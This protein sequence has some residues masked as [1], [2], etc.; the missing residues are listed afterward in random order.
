MGTG[1]T[2]AMLN[3][4]DPRTKYLVVHD[5]LDQCDSVLA[6]PSGVEFHQPSNTSGSKAN[7]LVRLVRLGKN[8]ATTHALYPSLVEVARDGYLRDY[9]IIIDE[10]LDPVK[11]M[12]AP[13]E[14]VWDALVAAGYVYVDQNT[15]KVIPTA[16]WA[17]NLQRVDGTLTQGLLEAATAGLLYITEKREMFVLPIPVELVNS[18]NSVTIAT[19]R[20]RGS[21]LAAYLDKMGIPYVI[22]RDISLDRKLRADVRRWVTV[23]DIPSLREVR[24]SKSGQD[25]MA[26]SDCRKVQVALKNVRQ[27]QLR[28]TPTDQILVGCA[29]DSWYHTNGRKTYEDRTG[30]FSKG[31]GLFTEANWAPARVRGTNEFREC[32]VVFSLYDYHISPP[33]LEWLGKEDDK[34]FKDEYA[35]SELLQF[36]FRSRIRCRETLADPSIT[37]YIPSERMRSLFLDWANDG[38]PPEAALRV[39]R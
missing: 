9:V 28:N 26:S 20:A 25:K 5:T 16:R 2:T 29:K 6:N 8:I 13:Q 7:D 38:V 31:T 17:E 4:F 3:G 11:R 34:Q 37:L 36:V 23:K 21:T 22:D 10:V 33:V 19:Y 30:K 1:K 35:L 15:G 12:P 32:S 39:T 14:G 27:R 24:F 18:G